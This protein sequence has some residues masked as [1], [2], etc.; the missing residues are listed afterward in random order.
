MKFLKKIVKK[1]CL[2]RQWF[3]S[4]FDS[5]AVLK[6]KLLFLQKSINNDKVE[7]SKALIAQLLKMAQLVF[8][9]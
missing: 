1:D 5:M 8:E 7:N 3:I 2:N 4:N 6:Q 9:N